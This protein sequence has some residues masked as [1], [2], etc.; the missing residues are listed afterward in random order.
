MDYRADFNSSS[1]QPSAFKCN[2]LEK[3]RFAKRFWKINAT[4]KILSIIFLN[5]RACVI[6]ETS[7]RYEPSECYLNTSWRIE[8]FTHNP[9]ELFSAKWFFIDKDS[10]CVFFR[11]G[12]A[13]RLNHTPI[14]KRAPFW[15]KCWWGARYSSFPND[16]HFYFIVFRNTFTRIKGSINR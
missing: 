2:Y 13:S 4:L 5:Y 14:L 1:R 12:I 16:L 9:R 3:L 8:R 11:Y 6:V 7:S 10:R 15:G